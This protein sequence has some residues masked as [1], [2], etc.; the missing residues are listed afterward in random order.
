MYV[1]KYLFYRSGLALLGG[2]HPICQRGA[3]KLFG[4]GTG[5]IHSILETPKAPTHPHPWRIGVPGISTSKDKNHVTAPLVSK[6]DIVERFV[7]GLVCPFY[8]FILLHIDRYVFFSCYFFPFRWL[9]GLIDTYSGVQP[10]TDEVHIPAGRKG[11]VKVWYDEEVEAGNPDLIKVSKRQFNR[12]W[13]ERLPH[14][15]CRAFLRS[16]PLS[17]SQIMCC[18]FYLL[19]QGLQY[20]VPAPQSK[21]R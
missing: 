19:F 11:D 1:H 17:S 8:T 12:I 21:M 20:V 18:Y 7:L 5:L 10:D 14:L 6:G 2:M 4:I 16:P 13:L 3:K 9:H 15:K